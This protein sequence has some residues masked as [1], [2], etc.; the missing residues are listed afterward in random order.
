MIKGIEIRNILSNVE[1]AF[2][3]YCNMLFPKLGTS[4]IYFKRFKKIL[5]WNNPQNISEKLSV[6]KLRYNKDELISKC[7]DKYTVREY[8]KECGL[9]ELLVRCNI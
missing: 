3:C 7:S 4:L 1:S 8:I 5:H 2:F 6:L 9:D